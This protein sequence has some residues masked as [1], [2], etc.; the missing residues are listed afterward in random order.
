MQHK[1]L[2]GIEHGECLRDDVSVTE[3]YLA[4]CT[5]IDELPF[6]IRL[7]Y[8]PDCSAAYSLAELRLHRPSE[9]EK[10]MVNAGNVII[11]TIEMRWRCENGF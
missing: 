11:A 3:R 9:S 7:V 8:H 1:F 6:L 5:I 4:S 10:K 2:Q